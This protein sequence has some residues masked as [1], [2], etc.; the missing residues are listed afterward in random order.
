MKRNTR[1]KLIVD[2]L[3]YWSGCI[4]DMQSD[5]EVNEFFENALLKNYG[6]HYIDGWDATLENMTNSQ[7]REFRQIVFQSGI[8][9]KYNA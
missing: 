7:L 2:I 5:L 4:N 3:E 9:E 8:K 6:I 1:Q